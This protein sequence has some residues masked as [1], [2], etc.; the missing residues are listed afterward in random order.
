MVA[1]AHGIRSIAFPAIST[2]IFGYPFKEAQKI[3][4]E[5]VKAYIESNSGA[6]DTIVFVYHKR[7]IQQMREEFVH[8]ARREKSFSNLTPFPKDFT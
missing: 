7:N 5:T 2:R 3:A 4:F 6:F 8:A 1:N